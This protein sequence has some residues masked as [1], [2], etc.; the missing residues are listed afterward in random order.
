MDKN[1]NKDIN[2]DTNNDINKILSRERL[3][4]FPFCIRKINDTLKTISYPKA[5]ENGYFC[6]PN[7]ETFYAV[8]PNYTPIPTSM[9][10]ICAKISP[11]GGISKLSYE[12][13]PNFVT[14]KDCVAFI[15][16]ARYVP[17]TSPLFLYKI[18]TK[19]GDRIIPS[20]DSKM[21]GGVQ[22]EISPIY[23]LRQKII[24]GRP[25]GFECSLNYKCI[26]TL[27][28]DKKLIDCVVSCN[29]N[30][31]MDIFSYALKEGNE[32]T[33]NP[34]KM[35]ISKLYKRIPFIW[36]LVGIIILLIFILIFSRYTYQR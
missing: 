32:N 15:T 1:V 4:L 29:Q 9:V 35:G 26:P 24:D 27:R 20:F 3:D 33:F 11:D 30:P 36:A 10:L 18:S 16:W 22:I 23:V 14:L 2:K 21:D 13:D 34:G 8:I 17:Y 12:R 25:I 19:D 6:D 31:P 28:S 7:D 5:N